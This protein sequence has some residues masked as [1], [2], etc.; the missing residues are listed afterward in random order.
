MLLDGEC[1]V[2]SGDKAHMS[3]SH[4]GNFFSRTAKNAHENQGDEKHGSLSGLRRFSLGTKCVLI[5]PT[6]IS[7]KEAAKRNVE[8]NGKA[9]A[10]HH[11]R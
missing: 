6:N 3:A 5:N 11:F 9:P 10:A 8:R 2:L 7:E 1:L 4:L